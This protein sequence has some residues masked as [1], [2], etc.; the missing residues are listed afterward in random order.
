MNFEQATLRAGIL[1]ALAHPYR[2]MMVDHLSKGDCC[3]CE[4]NEL[5]ELD[6]SGVSRHLAILKQAGI[7]REYRVGVKVYHHL[8]TPC[9]LKAFDCALQAIRQQSE[10]TR[11]V[12]AGA[13]A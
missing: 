8:Q 10:R 11:E 9:I 5:F 2:V 13:S 1:K 3:V 4:L 7:I 12:L 6:Q